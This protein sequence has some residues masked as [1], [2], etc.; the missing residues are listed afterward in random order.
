MLVYVTPDV[1]MD[2]HFMQFGTSETAYNGLLL[3]VK[4]LFYTCVIRSQTFY[5]N[6]GIIGCW[7]GG[8]VPGRQRSPIIINKGIE[9]NVFRS[10][11]LSHL[12]CFFL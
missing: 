12:A 11:A 9:R 4:N 7:C 6:N 1:G 5:R 8:S 3:P 2:D 10:M